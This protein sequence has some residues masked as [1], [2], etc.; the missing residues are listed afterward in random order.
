MDSDSR[1]KGKASNRRTTL[2]LYKSSFQLMS[3]P[4]KSVQLYPTIQLCSRLHSTLPALNSTQ[5]CSQL[6]P[7]LFNSTR[8]CSVLPNPVLNSNQL[9][10]TLPNAAQL[11]STQLLSSLRA[12]G[13]L[14]QFSCLL[15]ALFSFSQLCSILF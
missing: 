4:L 10:S 15:S 1:K 14:A 5:L 8:P 12:S 9:C 3:T 13:P 11:Y 2:R 7:T 6:Y